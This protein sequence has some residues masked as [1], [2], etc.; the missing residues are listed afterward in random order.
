MHKAQ[1]HTSLTITVRLSVDPRIF[2]AG[3]KY[4]CSQGPGDATECPFDAD[5]VSYCQ[6]SEARRYR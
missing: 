3:L 5:R 4:I 1:T 2:G 6:G